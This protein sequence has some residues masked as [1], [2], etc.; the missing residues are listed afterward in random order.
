MSC[1]AFGDLGAGAVVAVEGQGEVLVELR[2]VGDEAGAKTVEDGHREAFGV[3]VGLQHERRDG[4][5]EDGLGDAAGAVAAEVAGDFAA[6]GG[7]ADHDGVLEVEEV[8][9]LGEIVGVVVH[10]VAVPGLAGAAVAAAVVRDDAIALLAEEEHLGVPGVGGEGPAVREGDGLSG[11]PVFVVDGGAV[12]GGDVRHVC[13]SLLFGDAEI[14]AEWDG[15]P[16][17]KGW[18][19]RFVNRMQVLAGAED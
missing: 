3:L 13:F 4:A 17:A 5:D 7:V 16:V 15:L 10:V 1:D 11:A 14:E 12:F 9:E 18:I 6:A 2:A 19:L 8:V